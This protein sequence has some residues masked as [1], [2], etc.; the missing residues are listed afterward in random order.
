MYNQKINNTL[1]RNKKK[2][3][4][5]LGMIVTLLVLSITTE[6]L[7]IVLAIIDSRR[8]M[9]PFWIM[10]IILLFIFYLI[11]AAIFLGY[12]ELSD[13]ELIIRNALYYHTRK[14]L[15]TMTSGKWKSVMVAFTTRA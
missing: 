4:S 11:L 7:F 1:H 13:N 6:G 14:D 9:I 8:V 15:R 2:Y 12:P 10:I 5:S 3:L